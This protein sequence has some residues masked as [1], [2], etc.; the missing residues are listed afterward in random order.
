MIR[1][2][3]VCQAFLGGEAWIDFLGCFLTW[4][5]T[6]PLKWWM[7]E[8]SVSNNVDLRPPP[9]FEI[10]DNLSWE[11][12]TFGLSDL[13]NGQLTVERTLIL[14]DSLFTGFYW[15]NG[16]GK[17]R[18]LLLSEKMHEQTWISMFLK[19]WLSKN[20]CQDCI[21][22]FWKPAERTLTCW[23]LNLAKI[24]FKIPLKQIHDTWK[25]ERSLSSIACFFLCP[26]FLPIFPILKRLLL[27]GRR[28]RRK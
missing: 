18:L 22:N 13:W 20:K 2:S 24:K 28:E 7:R 25:N 11:H 23:H 5:L 10:W 3:P 12:V 15:T 27:Q 16:C 9:N 19:V 4:T 26:L 21:S 14:L 17:W 1:P 8:G 6:F